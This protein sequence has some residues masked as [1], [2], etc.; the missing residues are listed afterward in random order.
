MQALPLQPLSQAE[1]ERLQQG[2]EVLEQDSR[3]LKVLRLADGDML[4]LFRV[5]RLLSSARLLPYSRRFCRNA[6]R[7][8][9]Y[10]VPTVS[11][12]AWYRLP[13]PGL[14]AVLYRP[15]PGRTLRQIAESGCMDPDLLRQL[16]SFVAGLHDKGV[17]F[18][19]LHLGNIVRT[20]AGELGL[21]DIADL[22]IMHWRLSGRRRLRNFRHMCR[23]EQDREVFGD[24][25][26]KLFLERYVLAAPGL[27]SNFLGQ[28]RRVFDQA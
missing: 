5:K 14:T 16:G 27:A 17:Y 3:G 9:Q 23:L 10:G 18:R 11:V 1:F 20:P 28:A 22:G 2:A 24:E 21:I 13:A 26:W 8:A 19:S 7:L 6:A 12:K 15:L 4:K 25:G